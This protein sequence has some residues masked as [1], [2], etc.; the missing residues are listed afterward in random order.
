MI[1]LML[2]IVHIFIN[3]FRRLN[4]IMRVCVP[5]INTLC[6]ILLDW[7]IDG[8]CLYT[9]LRIKIQENQANWILKKYT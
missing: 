3:T 4:M 1:L 6:L 2:C 9:L 5:I 8:I 7:I